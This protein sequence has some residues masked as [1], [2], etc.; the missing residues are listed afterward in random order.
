MPIEEAKR[1]SVERRI[2]DSDQTGD[3][4]NRRSGT[5]APLFRT[6][7]PTTSTSVQIPLKSTLQEEPENWSTPEYAVATTHV[8]S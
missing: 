8:F 4:V 3:F 2:W 5:R 6:I 1:S 7:A